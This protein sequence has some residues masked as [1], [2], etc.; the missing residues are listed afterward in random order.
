MKHRTRILSFLLAVVMLFSL[1]ACT[2]KE[3]PSTTTPEQP[4][5]PSDAQGSDA[6]DATTGALPAYLHPG[7][8]PLTDEPITLRIAVLCSD[9]TTDPEAT[10]TYKLLEEGLGID[11]E[12]EYFYNASRDESVSMMMASGDL[13]DLIIGAKLTPE[14]LSRYGEVEG[15]FLDMAPY[16]NEENAPNL[17]KFYGENP[18]YLT[19]LT[20][21]NGKVYSLGGIFVDADAW[22]SQRMYYNYDMLE[23]MGYTDVPETLDE[24]MQMLRDMKA[25]GEEQGQ[26]IVPFGGNYADYNPMHLIL[27]A[28]GYNRS[29]DQAAIYHETD[30]MLRDGQVVM[31]AY[32]REVFPTYLE[33]LHTMYTEGL[34]E[35]DYY[36][37]DGDTTTA[38][39]TS[40]MYGVFYQV[41]G[42]FGGVEFG[43]QWWGGKPLTSAYNDTPFWPNYTGQVVGQYVISADTAY[44]ELCVAV[45]DF[46]Y[47]PNHMLCLQGPS[48]NDTEFLLGFDGFRYYP[49]YLDTSWD[50]F[51]E[52][53]NAYGSII[54][55]MAQK[56]WLWDNMSFYIKYSTDFYDENGNF[57]GQKY[58]VS[59]DT[60]MEQAAVRKEYAT[61]DQQYCAAQQFTWGQYL[62]DE[63]SPVTV[64]FDEETSLRVAELKTLIEEYAQQEIAKFVI[65]DRDLSEVDAFFNEL[66]SL[67]ADEYIG[68]YV[69]YYAAS[70]G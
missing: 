40:G 22:Q 39:L 69:D 26:T 23:A 20:N 4:A 30:I 33:T 57:I 17:S 50:E 14:E 11:V 56:F 24:F 12:L 15:M 6:S 54:D 16:L 51:E 27:N 21:Q 8:A 48:C 10:Y 58:E 41:P 36:T 19:E 28:L 53:P 5:A 9:A 52:N 62:T 70:A 34:M 55:Y 38:H 37:M 64:Y 65:G 46:F 32:D 42:V 60:M 31:P 49:E 1:C 13:P 63:F 47:G 29:G 25:Y 66:E 3:D 7:Q 61:F 59:G 67:G 44:P 35:Q 43:S 2:A 45:A 68:Y 18:Q